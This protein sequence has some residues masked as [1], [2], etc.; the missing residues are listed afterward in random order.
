M[1]G[2]PVSGHEPIARSDYDLKP[3]PPLHLMQ[4]WR[5]RP[6]Q[7]TDLIPAVQAWDAYSA[8]VRELIIKKSEGYGNAWQAQGY[9]GNLGRVLSKVSRLKSLL[10]KDTGPDFSVALDGSDRDPQAES[11][12]DTL[13][14]LGAVAAFAVA[15]L[16]EGNRWGS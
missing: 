14:D 15:N 2:D 10:W 5:G 9:M 3:E 4:S 13:R 16:D 7:A 1:G 11:V 8:Q 6:V 12:I